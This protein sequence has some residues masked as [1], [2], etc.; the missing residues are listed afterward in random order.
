L[1]F[2]RII[3]STVPLF[4][5]SEKLRRFA[6]FSSL[7]VGF[8]RPAFAYIKWTVL[9]LPCTSYGG[10]FGFLSFVVALAQWYLIYFFFFFGAIAAGHGP[11]CSRELDCFSSWPFFFPPLLPLPFGSMPLLPGAFPTPLKNASPLLSLSEKRRLSSSSESFEGY[12]LEI[13]APPFF[14]FPCMDGRPISEKGV[15]I[16]SFPFFSP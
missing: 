6:F 10:M 14:S 3:L 11:P 8:I 5:P 1:L 4:P 9:S 16:K 7:P 13:N 12:E 15:F 2:L